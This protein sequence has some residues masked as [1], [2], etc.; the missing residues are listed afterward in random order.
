MKKI[1][2]ITVVAFMS[3][4][5]FMA[6]AFGNDFNST[7]AES[8]FTQMTH[9]IS[10]ADHELAER[11]CGICKVKIEK[12]KAEMNEQPIANEMEIKT[13][14]TYKIRLQKFCAM[15]SFEIQK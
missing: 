4:M 2:N 14:E 15:K 6:N 10:Q 9:V 11:M 1:I 12:Y 13:L 5:V 8:Q 3:L 7:E